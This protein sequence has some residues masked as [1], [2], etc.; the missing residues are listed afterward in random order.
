MIKLYGNR[1]YSRLHEIGSTCKIASDAYSNHINEA[2]LY[3][4]TLTNFASLRFNKFK[5]GKIPQFLIETCF[6]VS[7][8]I[9]RCGSKIGFKILQVVPNVNF[10]IFWDVENK[11]TGCFLDLMEIGKLALLKYCH[12]KV[13]WLNIVRDLFNCVNFLFLKASLILFLSCISVITL[14]DFR[15][16]HAASLRLRSWSRKLYVYD[17]LT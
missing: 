8:L 13:S 16:K 17:L 4:N 1:G 9:L 7:T 2:C 14:C 11:K 15:E 10:S 12:Y 3:A 5:A 6:H